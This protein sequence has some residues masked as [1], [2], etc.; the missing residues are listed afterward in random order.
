MSRR[1]QAINSIHAAS[2]KQGGARITKVQSKRTCIHFVNWCFK[3]NHIINS[4]SDVNVETVQSYF[5]H[6]QEIQ[7]S[8][9]TQQN[10]LSAIRRSIQALGK[11]PNVTGITAKNIGIESR[12]R[13]GTKEPITDA[14]LLNAIFKAETL[15][16]QGLAIVLK[17]QRLL[18]YRGLESL[19]SLP[20]LENFAIE[21][22]T[23]A[24]TN[25]GV[26]D[27]TKG[28]RP[29]YTQIIHA[30]AA[31]TY[32]VIG[33]AL[34]YMRNHRYLVSGSKAGLK[35]A[36]SKYHALASQVGLVGKF[37]PHSLRYAYAVE[38][39]TELRDQGYNRQEAMALVAGFLGHGASRSRYISMVYG[40]TVVHTV[41]V[42]KRKA[43]IDRAISN[44]DKLLDKPIE[45][46]TTPNL[47]IA[48]ASVSY[49]DSQIP[50]MNTTAPLQHPFS[51]E[52]ASQRRNAS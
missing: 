31:E 27:G 20:A 38:K 5:K 29:R 45:V 49:N 23:I 25:I 2:K 52:K 28:G 21:A 7:L 48:T 40:K 11:D 10:R 51:S 17:L 35:T 6:L 13:A 39:I 43:R 8:V 32:G 1:T 12:N 44:L 42:E 30:R 9:A 34:I 33:E 4:I 46:D 41:P 47:P 15:G 24:S 14:L 36:R 16:E 22:K 3:N 50:N 37:S 18:G 26:R 19:M